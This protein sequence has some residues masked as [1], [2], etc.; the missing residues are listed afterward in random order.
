MAPRTT[1]KTIRL[2]GGRFLDPRALPGYDPKTGTHRGGRR[3][4]GPFTEGKVN[5]FLARMPEEAAARLYSEDGRLLG[6][7]QKARDGRFVTGGFDDPHLMNPDPRGNVDRPGAAKALVEAGPDYVV[8]DALW[9]EDRPLGPLTEVTPHAHA[10]VGRVVED[11]GSGGFPTLERR[12]IDFW[13][14]SLLPYGLA[15][16]ALMALGYTDTSDEVAKALAPTVSEAFEAFKRA[17]P[18][19]DPGQGPDR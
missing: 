2:D 4:D 6:W 5:N 11:P 10:L 8:H 7:L 3:W 19:L 9:Q 1:A 12:K 17:R 18:D 16:S 15:H 13:R 14:G